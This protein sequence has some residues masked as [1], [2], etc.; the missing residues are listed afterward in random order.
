MKGKRRG[1]AVVIVTG[2]S[3]RFQKQNQSRECQ[4]KAEDQKKR[5]NANQE[6]G[7]TL[8]IHRVGLLT[9]LVGGGGGQIGLTVAGGDHPCTSLHNRTKHMLG[10]GAKTFC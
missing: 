6:R 3:T 1:D 4:D 8:T 9:I 10:L 5:N 7:G 2:K